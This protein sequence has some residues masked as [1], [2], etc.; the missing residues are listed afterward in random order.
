MAL[1]KENVLTHLDKIL[2]GN[3][4]VGDV[5]SVTYLAVKEPLI[6]AALTMLRDVLLGVKVA[7]VSPELVAKMKGFVQ[8]ICQNGF[9]T[10][11]SGS[12]RGSVTY[13]PQQIAAVA[14]GV[15]LDL[16]LWA[17]SQ[18]TVLLYGGTVGV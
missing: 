16:L 4:T 13:D 18:E 12:T 10:P 9:L 1:L 6:L 15:C 11:T 17:A 7:S 3:S 14:K 2:R 8:G 5:S